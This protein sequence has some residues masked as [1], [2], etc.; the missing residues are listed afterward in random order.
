[1]VTGRSMENSLLQ[2][3][4]TRHAGVWSHLGGGTISRGTAGKKSLLAWAA[5]RDQIVKKKKGR[6]VRN[7]EEKEE[8]QFLAVWNSAADGDSGCPPP[9][10][11]IGRG[12]SGGAKEDRSGACPKFKKGPI[13]KKSRI[14]PTL[15]EGPHKTSEEMRGPKGL[16]SEEIHEI[17]EVRGILISF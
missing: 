10:L 14:K 17:K 16:Q 15:Q 12:G 7:L 2:G 6:G 11:T 8:L 13:K 5:K 1:V 4:Q 9:I 3:V